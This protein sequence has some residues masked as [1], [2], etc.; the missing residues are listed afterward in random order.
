[1]DNKGIFN[2]DNVT[3]RQKKLRDKGIFMS[4]KN[5]YFDPELNIKD[6]EGPKQDLNLLIGMTLPDAKILVMKW[7]PGINFEDSEIDPDDK[8]CNMYA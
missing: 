1:M 8:E 5:S 6:V 7:H 3:F 2:L 4:T